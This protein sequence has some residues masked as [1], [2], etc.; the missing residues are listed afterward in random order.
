MIKLSYVDYGSYVQVRV[1]G[2]NHTETEQKF[3]SFWNHGATS[4]EAD[5]IED[6]IAEFWTTKTK[7]MKAFTNSNLFKIL[8]ATPDKY[9]GQKGG[10]L[11]EAKENA[12]TEYASMKKCRNLSYLRKAGSYYNV[13]EVEVED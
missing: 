10:A 3:N 9:K 11:A 8:N 1:E 5:W 13:A 7:L 6:Y 12:K 4:R 2:D